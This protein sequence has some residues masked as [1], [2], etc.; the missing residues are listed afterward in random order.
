[1]NLQYPVI[2]GLLSLLVVG[3]LRARSDGVVGWVTAILI[4]TPV[5]FLLVPLTELVWLAL[6]FE[7]AP[8][9]PVLFSLVLFL[10][11][12]AIESLGHP[13][14]WWAPVTGLIL[15]LGALGMGL[16]NSR[17]NAERPAPST[18]VY[19]YEHGTGA[20]MW[21]TD[22]T[23]DSLDADATAW[24]VEKAGGSFDGRRDLSGFAYGNGQKPT[25]PAPVVSAAPPEV[26]ITRDTVDAG[27][28]HVTLRIRSRIGAEYLA[29]GYDDVGS[30]RLVSLNGS[31]LAHPEE[32]AF[33]EHWGEPNPSVV[34]ELEMPEGQAIGLQVV[35][36]LLRPEELL[37]A[38]AF[39]RPP[40][41]APNV[42][43]LSDRAMFRYSVGAFAD[44]R[45]AILMP[46]AQQPT[47]AP[48]APTAGAPAAGVTPAD[49]LPADTLPVDTVA[50]DTVTA[51][52]PSGD[53]ASA[54]PGDTASVDTLA[55]D[56]SLAGTL[57]DDTASVDTL[58]A[59]PDTTRTPRGDGW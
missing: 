28:R 10:C 53:T 19:A 30:T 20:A 59:S 37:G 50:Q 45:H 44:P 16:L 12:P 56:T 27:T 14:R 6:R 24:A 25:A 39:D 21:V 36:H 11:V 32:L 5:L 55:G 48:S 38:D 15:G 26:I 33:A 43:R 46:G 34:L 35:E 52:P 47:G 3:V 29:F 2:A 58:A 9:F 18:L 23:Q 42:M 4:T 49:T 40:H 31:P 7:L 54:T 13:N 41:L 1:M 51:E 57:P 17:S 8:F 22:P